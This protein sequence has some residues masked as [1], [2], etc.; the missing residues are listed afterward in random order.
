M[1]QQRHQFAEIAETSFPDLDQ[2]GFMWNWQYQP[3]GS[4]K[5][6]TAPSII[7]AISL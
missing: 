6:T 7:S 5:K 4:I 1:S 2:P 3:S